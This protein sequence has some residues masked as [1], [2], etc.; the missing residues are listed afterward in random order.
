MK[1]ERLSMN[2]LRR[3]AGPLACFFILLLFIAVAE[4]R[5]AELDFNEDIGLSL[6]NDDQ[7]EGDQVLTKL[8]VFNNVVM[9]FAPEARTLPDTKPPHPIAPP[10]P[11]LAVRWLEP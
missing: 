2:A 10:E 7:L 5:V 3:G 4:R 11:L 9:P 1:P 6:E 8:L